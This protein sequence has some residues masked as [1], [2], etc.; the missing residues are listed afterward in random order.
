MSDYKNVTYNVWKYLPMSFRYR[1]DNKYM[2]LIRL[3]A[4]THRGNLTN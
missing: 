2:V 3:G 4:I 1:F